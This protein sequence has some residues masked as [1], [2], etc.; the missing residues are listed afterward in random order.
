MVRRWQLSSGI[1]STAVVLSGAASAADVPYTADIGPVHLTGTVDVDDSSADVW[2]VTG[3]A[4]GAV[5]G[6][7]NLDSVNTESEIT[8]QGMKLVVIFNPRDRKLS[9]R[10]DICA[11][12]DSCTAGNPVTVWQGP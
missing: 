5:S 9:A 12:P 1:I 7:Y 11:S 6:K 2:S 8:A 10:L 4:S 3:Q